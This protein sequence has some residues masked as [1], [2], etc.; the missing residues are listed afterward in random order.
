MKRLIIFL[1]IN[2]L[3][4]NFS[5]GEE[6]L[7]QKGDY[8]WA[9]SDNSPFNEGVT[10][11]IDGDIETK[12]LNFE[13]NNSGLIVRPRNGPTIAKRIQLISANDATK[14]DPTSVVVS[15][16]NDNK[17]FTTIATINLNFS[18]KRFES[19]FFEFNN[20]KE[21]E[22]YKITFPDVKDKTGGFG[23]SV[24]ISEIQLF[25]D[26]TNSTEL[27]Y[28]EEMIPE[29][30][31]YGPVKYVKN[32]SEPGTATFFEINGGP[33][34]FELPDEID[35]FPIIAVA[36]YSTRINGVA[37]FICGKNVKSIG[38]LAFNSASVSDLHLSENLDFIGRDALIGKSIT[39]INV[40]LDNPYYSSENG[41]LYTKDFTVLHTIPP[42]FGRSVILNENTLKINRKACYEN[43]LIENLVFNTS[44][45]EI[46]DSAF[47][48]CWILN[49][50][51]LPAT[52]KS[53]G[54]K[55]FY[56]C[57]EI[58]N[59]RLGRN[60]NYIGNSFVNKDI[61]DN[62]DVSAKNT[63][64]VKDDLF[65]Y[66]S[67]SQKLLLVNPNI[68]GLVKIPESINIIGDD[69][70]RGLK[71]IGTVDMSNTIEVI[72]AGAFR[73]SS[74]TSLVN[75]ESLKNIEEQAF[76]GAKQLE[77]IEI[78]NLE[79]VGSSAFAHCTNLRTVVSLGSVDELP[80]NIFG[81]CNELIDVSGITPPST[82][83]NFAFSDCL[84]LKVLFNTYNCTYVGNYAFAACSSLE[85]TLELPS[86][87]YIGDFAF[88]K[89]AYEKI[90]L[91]ESLTYLGGDAFFTV[92]ETQSAIVIPIE[93]CDLV[94][95]PLRNRYGTIKTL[96][97]ANWIEKLPQIEN[98]DIVAINKIIISPV[99]KQNYNLLEGGQFHLPLEIN[100][101]SQPVISLFL[102]NNFTGFL[103]VSEIGLDEWQTSLAFN[104]ISIANNGV[105]NIYV[106]NDDYL[107]PLSEISINVTRVDTDQDGIY[108][109]EEIN[110]GTDPYSVDTDSDNLSDFDE[111][112]V[113]FIN[114]LKADS[115]D[116]LLDDFFEVFIYNTNPSDPDS[117]QDLLSDY[118]EI[119]LKPLPTNPLISDTDN[120]G[121]PDG[122]EVSLKLNPNNIDSDGDGLSDFIEVDYGLNPLI[123]SEGPEGKA[124]ISLAVQIKFFTLPG[125]QYELMGSNNNNDWTT[126]NLTLI[127]D[128][129]F[130]SLFIPA[131]QQYYFYK[132]VKIE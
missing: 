11:A 108:D 64:L 92:D 20:V 83:G 65:L 33:L 75:V 34:Q 121:L 52:L 16:S 6:A 4:L 76:H 43:K 70:F 24:Q 40:S 38:S 102:N 84:N 66:N 22:Y 93:S 7:F 15:G 90:I 9:T 85:G 35:G 107:V 54:T 127:G 77:A 14:R 13:P 29:I 12:Y 17:I 1:L 25:G 8:C 26:R 119:N 120:D 95:N 105:F 51:E 2:C 74:I 89:T 117:D 109:V 88:R 55:S 99:K 56:K 94:G 128:G 41:I 47:E 62:I 3:N 82:I 32:F 114:P 123:P 50:V 101:K 104:P 98:F 37:E 81:N 61:F 80:N 27:L 73:D 106:E 79:N 118:D 130:R 126:T 63:S 46:G 124:T 28:N 112:Y 86:A 113:Y 5:H 78:P 116:D 19:Y 31:R 59:F 68:N 48:G 125:Q 58:T 72:G 42:R 53:L 87:N 30:R 10:Q 111:L 91:S 49:N 21:F 71:L 115:D 97:S 132:V 36:A 96:E 60:V 18:E 122:E 69:T 100:S 57:P 129:N 67:T 131:D 103:S 44:L 110:L 39:R 23:D 45:L